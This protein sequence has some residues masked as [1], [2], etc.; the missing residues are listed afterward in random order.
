MSGQPSRRGARILSQGTS[1]PT[2]SRRGHSR[3]QVAEHRVEESKEGDR[4]RRSGS[5]L[6]VMHVTPQLARDGWRKRRRT[7]RSPPGERARI[8]SRTRQATALLTPDSCLS[9]RGCGGG[10]MGL[11]FLHEKHE[12]NHGE[13]GEA[14]EP[15]RVGIGQHVCLT[16]QVAVD[17]AMGLVQR[18][19][20]V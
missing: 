10:A 3:S 1:I 16:D 19:H 5:G 4:G 13:E 8:Q 20:G 12:G 14:E 15:K 18:L 2:T 6:N 7:P 9:V 11:G 17:E